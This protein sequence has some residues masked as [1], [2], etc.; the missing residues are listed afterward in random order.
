MSGHLG[1]VLSAPRTG[2]PDRRVRTLIIGAGPTGLGAAWRLRERGDDDW[3]VVDSASVA[4]GA[5]ASAHDRQGFV[6][7]LGGHVLHS[8]FRYF[9]EVVGK[10]VEDWSYPRRAGWASVGGLLSPTPVQRNLGHLTPELGRTVVTEIGERTKP[11]EHRPDLGSWFE[12]TFGPTLTG[13][14]FRP[15]NTKMWAH[16]PEMLSHSWTSLRSGSTAAN[17]P[18]PRAS[19]DRSDRPAEVTT[20]PFPRGGTGSL[21]QAVADGFPPGA[22]RYGVTVVGVDLDSRVATVSDGTSIGFE[23][24]ISSMPLPA[25]ASV[26]G[27][28]DLAACSATLRSSAVHAV[29]FGFLGEPPPELARASWVYSADADVP[30]HR[31]TVLS[32]YSDRMAGPG[33]WSILTESATSAHRLLDACSIIPDSLAALRP[34]GVTGDPV[35]TWHRRLPMGYPIPTLGRDAVLRPVQAE[36][37]AAGIR[38][39]GRFGGWRYES[40]NQDHAFMQGVEAVDAAWSGMPETVYGLS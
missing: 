10:A 22:I 21:W 9:D 36:L 17:V 32:N 29:G 2:A 26:I 24:C 12:R 11:A 23:E 35:S 16:P 15:L 18:A 7:D 25:L 8:H 14:F 28:P 3:V 34:W 31:A 4:G 33:R 13:M 40:S 39:R 27:R 6:W 19:L 1:P 38:S 37:L 20:F 30:F 5:S